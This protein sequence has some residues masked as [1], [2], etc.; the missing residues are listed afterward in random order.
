[1]DPS[2][3]PVAVE[4]YQLEWLERYEHEH[5]LLQSVLDEAV[6]EIQHFGS[7]SIPGMWAKPTVDILLGTSRWPW[8][9]MLDQALHDAGYVFYKAPRERWRV[10][11]KSWQHLRRGYHLHIVEF[12]SEHWIEHLLFRDYLRYNRHDA[13]VYAAL[14]RDLAQSHEQDRGAYQ[15]QKAELVMELMKRAKAWRMESSASC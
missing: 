10:Y 13:A 15:H 6:L 8:P 2:Q 1:M 7:T 3:E 5:M 9:P 4:P 12:A 14:K 11:L